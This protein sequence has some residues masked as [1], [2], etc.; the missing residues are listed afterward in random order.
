MRSTRISAAVSGRTAGAR[1]AATAAV[2]VL[3]AAAVPVSGAGAAAT[4]SAH[5]PSAPPPRFVSGP[6]PETPE[7]IP[8][9]EHA[10]CGF[11]E[12]PENRERPGGRTVRLAVAVVPAASAKPAAD[13]LVYM[14]GGPGGDAF[15]D[16][17]FLVEAGLNRDRE[18][19]VMAQRGNLHSR[20]NLAC[21]EIDRASAQ[22]VGLRYDDPSART[23]LLRAAE[24]CRGRLTADGTDLG[25][26]NTGEN[27]AD[28]ADLRTALGIPR[29][30][31]YAY[32]YGTDLALTYLRDHPQGIRAVALDSVTPPQ[33]VSLPWTWSSAR[34][35]ID[36]VLRACEAQPA[37]K[38]RYP[39]LDRTLAEQVRRLEERPLTLEAV[40]PQGGKPVKVVLDGGALLNLLVG[41]A[42]PAAEVPAALDE[43][44]RGNPERFAR[45]RAAGAHPAVGE[46][47]YGLTESVA[48]AEWAP[49]HSES[50]LLK[51]GRRAFPG[52]PDSVLTHAPQLP[53]QHEVCRVWNVPDRTGSQR[54]TPVS[55]VPTLIVS[56][57]FDAKTGASW[58]ERTARTLSGSTVVKIPGTGHFVVPQSPCA[59]QVLAS[60]LARP[61]APDTSCAADVRPKP[62]TIVPR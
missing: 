44:A 59:Q 57:T 22:A 61:T 3:L 43:L 13:P 53:F 4:P 19:I 39:D 18:L 28:F 45:A 30:N 23:L 31:V 15:G 56:G 38:S 62:F 42:V 48:C 34:E 2:L 41:N 27:A 12:V 6:C 9:L 16:I 7:P 32:S 51:A 54:V 60:F 46:T 8:V 26:Y 37:C 50:D 10:R 5:G 25:A 29:W 21:P 17:P 36:T 1:R 52:W 11:L 14:A 24:Q 55:P 40:P 47:A 35:G 20:P 33:T 58:G 49:G